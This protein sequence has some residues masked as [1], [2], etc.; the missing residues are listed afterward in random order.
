MP[1]QGAEKPVRVLIKKDT[2]NDINP[3]KLKFADNNYYNAYETGKVVQLS[4]NIIRIELKVSDENLSSYVLKG[5]S[6]E[7]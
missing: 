7:L 5:G 2:D 1:L 4:K 3:F 6:K